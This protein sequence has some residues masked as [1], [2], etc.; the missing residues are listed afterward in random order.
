MECLQET[1][2]RLIVVQNSLECVTTTCIS[3]R[4]YRHIYVRDEFLI[5]NII[6]SISNILLV[7]NKSK[8]LF[9]GCNLGFDSVIISK[10]VLAFIKQ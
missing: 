2:Y 7:K 4:C 8:I 1:Y 5:K 6:T 10:N 9:C 3:K